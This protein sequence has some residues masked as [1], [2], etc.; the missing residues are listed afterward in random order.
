MLQGRSLQR[1]G[2][3]FIPNFRK[4]QDKLDQTFFSPELCLPCL[5]LA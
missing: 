1:G 5:L 2:T 3:F 4:L